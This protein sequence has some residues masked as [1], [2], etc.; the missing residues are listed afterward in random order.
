MDYL[1]NYQRQSLL[2]SIEIF[3]YD[4]H[5]VTKIII[6]L[7]FSGIIPGMPQSATFRS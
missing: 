6:C 3:I 1:S 4:K 7:A 5:K 2:S